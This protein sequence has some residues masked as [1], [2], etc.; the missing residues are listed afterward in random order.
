[1]VHQEDALHRV[2]YAAHIAMSFVMA[3]SI[4]HP[5]YNFF[6][7]E[8]QSFFLS[9]TSIL[10][11]MVTVFMWLFTLYND[12]RQRSLKDF[13]PGYD[14]ALVKKQVL[15]HVAGIMAAVVLFCI[16]CGL[17]YSGDPDD[18]T[19]RVRRQ[20]AA[21]GGDPCEGHRRRLGGGSINPYA[22]DCVDREDYTAT[23]VLWTLA[24]VIEQLVNAYCCIYERVSAIFRGIYFFRCFAFL[25]T[26]SQTSH[27]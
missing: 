11:R 26:D 19:R 6:N 5:E 17:D 13:K 12:K 27:E 21:G 4:E 18:E 15:T 16:T 24:V 14:E 1:M 25:R 22:Y 3:I 20:L 9:M 8:K 7:F 23:I 2:Y 10:T